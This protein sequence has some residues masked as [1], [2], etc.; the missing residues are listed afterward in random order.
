MD[1]NYS[2]VEIINNLKS[3][4]IDDFIKIYS[5]L[6]LNEI[7][8]LDDAC[9]IVNNLTLHPTPIREALAYKLEEIYEEKFFN[10]FIKQKFLDAIIDINPN[11]SRAICAVIEKSPVLK[12]NLEEDIIIRIKKIINEIKEI[13]QVFKSEKNH[14]KNK[15]MFSLYWLL[16]ALSN[17]KSEKY[18]KD[19]IEIISQTL[20]FYDYTIREKGAKILAKTKNAPL[21]LLQKAKSDT[22]FYV[23]NQVYDKMTFED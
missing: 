8:S 7:K 20:G 10:D 5:I 11:V 3:E 2:Y 13:N 16:E 14:A 9:I 21:D 23:K 17:I 18:Q 15:K 1:N 12:E 4:S 22:N 19:L 6:D